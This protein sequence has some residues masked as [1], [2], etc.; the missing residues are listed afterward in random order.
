LTIAAVDGIDVLLIG[1]R[2]LTTDLGTPGQVD[3]PRLRT[4][5]E[6]VAA[7]CRAHEKALE[8]KGFLS[9]ERIA[10]MKPGVILVNTA[11]GA[12]VDEAAMVE[13]LR[14]G[15]IRH[16]GLD[17][18]AVEPLPAGHVLTTL[19][20][21]TLSAHSAFR[22]PEASDNLIGAALD[23]CRRIAAAGR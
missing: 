8:T 9:R 3:H 7:A 6:R 19:E 5:Y 4:A 1:S 22:T 18:F 15:H 23:H 13:A 21:V 12:L 20:N 11:R 17:V 10:A 14:S 2:D 16:A